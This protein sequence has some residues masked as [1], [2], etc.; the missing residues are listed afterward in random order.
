MISLL[1]CGPG[2]VPVQDFINL[3]Q[4]TA[5]LQRY[6]RQMR[7]K[8]FFCDDE[9]TVHEVSKDQGTTTFEDEPEHVKNVFKTEKTNLPQSNPPQSLT[10]T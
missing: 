3:S 4:T 5:D 6:N 9:N 10:H 2:F 7:W 8:E 1:N